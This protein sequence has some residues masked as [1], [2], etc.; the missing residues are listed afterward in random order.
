MWRI[1]RRTR[2][3]V[4]DDSSNSVNYLEIHITIFKFRFLSSEFHDTTTA[5]T[6]KFFSFSRYRLPYI[7]DLSISV[8]SND[9]QKIVYI[10]L[11]RYNI[12]LIDWVKGMN[13]FKSIARDS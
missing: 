8:I 1:R 7:Q 6:K 10:L 9:I 12:K 11:I 13:K 5:A 3:N 4:K 2:Q